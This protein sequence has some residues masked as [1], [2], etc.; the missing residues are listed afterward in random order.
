MNWL[1]LSRWLMLACTAATAIP[2]ATANINPTVTDEL[3]C[4]PTAPA[5]AP[6]STM[7]SSEMLSVPARSA[8]V[9]PMAAK[10]SSAAKRTAPE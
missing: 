8:M 5:K 10:A 7:P 2:T 6:P 1:A 3:R 9:S 4:M